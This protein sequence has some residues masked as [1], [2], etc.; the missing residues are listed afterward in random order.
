MEYPNTEMPKQIWA[1]KAE[2]FCEEDAWSEEKLGDSTQYIRA[3]Q[4]EA[5]ARALEDIV[6]SCLADEE[7]SVWSAYVEAGKVALE[8]YRK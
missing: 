6:R 5:L 8:E 2:I 3:D 7:C 1:W 4:A